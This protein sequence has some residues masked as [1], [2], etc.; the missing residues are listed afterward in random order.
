[1]LIR[2]YA[3]PFARETRLPDGT[4]ESVRRGAFD[5]SPRNTVR[6][7]IGGHDGPSIAWIS[8]SNGGDAQGDR[9]YNFENISGSAFGDIL[10]GDDQNNFLDGRLGN[11]VKGDSLEFAGR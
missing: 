10:T 2:G 7:L 8:R 6:L 3:C 9:F 5:L 1:M 4:I 11:F